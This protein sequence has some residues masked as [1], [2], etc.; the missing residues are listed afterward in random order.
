MTAER[1]LEL[2]G[3][4]LSL[5]LLRRFAPPAIRSWRVYS[6]A[7]TRR[8]ADAGPLAVAPSPPVAAALE[9]LG[10]L[11]FER[12]GERYL[13]LPGTGLRYDW[14]VG[15]KSGENLGEN[16]GATFVVV[17]PS[18]VVGAFVACYSVFPDGTW[19]QTHYPRGE[20]IERPDFVV[21]FVSTSIADTLAAHRRRLTALMAV[22]GPP[23]PVR[24]MADALWADNDYRTRHGGKTLQRLTLVIATPA[25]AAAGLALI[26]A[27]LLLLGR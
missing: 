22:H 10:R 17:V 15:E 20:T 5:V 19:L 1:V 4:F 16:V 3:L 23:R 27:A 7:K 24:S 13:Q 8:L 11:G 2:A 12:I 26:S 25:I 9:E 18:T 6:G 21:S 14:V